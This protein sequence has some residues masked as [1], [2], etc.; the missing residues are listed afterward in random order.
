MLRT[1]PSSAIATAVDGVLVRASSLG[2]AQRAATLE[3]HARAVATR[4]TETSLTE[5]R[6]RERQATVE[7]YAAGYTRAFSELC[8]FA[9][10][11]DA[12]RGMLLEGVLA[13]ARSVLASHCSSLDFNAAWIE[14]WCELHAGDGAAACRI[15]LPEHLAGLRERLAALGDTGVEVRVAP[16]PYITLE[17]GSLIHEFIP[18]AAIFD[19]AAMGA[20]MGDPGIERAIRDHAERFVQTLTQGTP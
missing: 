17:C 1:I 15:A 9:T 2:V 8:A 11:I 19:T 5:A 13:H 14:R 6:E 12:V 7:G 3:R 18:D 20:I 10:Q 16:V 4:I